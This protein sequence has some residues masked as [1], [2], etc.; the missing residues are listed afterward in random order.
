[1]PRFK[2]RPDRGLAV[3]TVRTPA[4]CGTVLAIYTQVSVNKRHRYAA[5]QLPAADDSRSRHAAFAVTE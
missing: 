1:M 3:G 2:R 5:R 4:D